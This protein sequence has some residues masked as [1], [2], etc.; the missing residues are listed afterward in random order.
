MS[1]D[2]QQSEPR[3]F[4]V[5]K[6]DD[7]RVVKL[8]LTEEYTNH[9]VPRSAR[10]DRLN[11]FGSWSSIA[12]AMAFVFY[13][14]LS[15][16]LVGV[17]Q[18]IIGL[19]VVTLC[20]SVL[21]SISADRAIRSGLNSTLLSRELFGTTGAALCP[22]L[23]AAAATYYA[24]FEGSIVALAL[25]SYFG[26]GDIRLWYVVVVVAT[27]PLMLGGIQTWLGKLNNLSLPIY[28][29]GLIAAVLVAG[30]RF[31]FDGD[32]SHFE[33]APSPLGI[34]GW[35]TVFVLYMGVWLL[36]PDTQDAAR[37]GRPHDA[38]F[39]RHITFGWGFYGLAFAFNGLVGILVVALAT[40]NTGAGTS[41]FGVVQAIIASLGIVGLLVI[42]VSQMRINS[43]NYY[44][45]SINM[46]RFV[47]HFTTRNLSRTTWVVV[48][49]AVVLALMFTDV[50]SYIAKALAWQ[51]VLLVAWVAMMIVSW[52]FDR[53]RD[54][55]FRPARLHAFAPGFVV[56]MVA[57]AAGIALIQLPTEFPRL[58]ALAPVVSF[59]VAV[60]LFTAVR[61]VGLT[62]LRTATPDPIREQVHDLWG[63][64]VRCDSCNLYYVAQEMDV[65]QSGRP[66][67]L[68]CQ[69]AGRI[70]AAK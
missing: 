68:T 47:A 8:Q 15:A 61:L 14:A 36:F 28:F 3:S 23:I 29:F 5:Q 46:E 33:G 35:V 50:F 65:D 19:V 41:E 4:D 34:P 48:L 10:H 27:L 62:G 30:I 11:L 53:G 32:W 6:S 25:Q 16:T 44:F 13:G 24:V 56:W 51:G 55:E 18:A 58:S 43:A 60:G 49:S 67:C 64:R 20:Y 39:H 17:Q 63:D 26:A 66:L 54:P 59:A 22:L 7:E 69:S 2:A 38:T 52:F 40:P 21:G 70:A 37:M 31:G 1:Q 9:V 45:A 57:A 12:S 42:I